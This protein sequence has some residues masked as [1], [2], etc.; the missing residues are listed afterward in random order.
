VAEPITEVVTAHVPGSGARMPQNDVERTSDLAVRAHL[1]RE[2]SRLRAL[3]RQRPDLFSPDLVAVLREIGQA[4]REAAAAS[5]S[6]LFL[7]GI[8]GPSSAEDPRTPHPGPLPG[9]PGRGGRTHSPPIPRRDARGRDPVPLA[10]EAGSNDSVPL[11]DRRDARGDSVPLADRR[12]VRGDSGSLAPV[13]RGEGGGE[14][15]APPPARDAARAVLRDTF[16]YEAFRPGQEEIIGAVLAGRDCVGVMPTGAGKSLTYQIPARVL[17]GTTLV[18]S[19]L[20][21][22]MKDQVD[23]VNE[24]GLRATFLNS[25]LSPEERRAR[26][27][28]VAA[29]AFELVYAAPEGI[30]AW[31]GQILA[32]TTLRL[33]AVDEAHCISQWGHDFRPAYRNLAGLKRRFGALPMLALTATATPEVT[34]DIIQQLA[35]QSP[36]VFRGSFFRPNLHLHGYRK[37]ETA[38]GVRKQVLRLVRSRPGQSGIIYCLS[39]RATESTAEFLR[40]HGVSALAYHAGMEP[41]ERTRV[42][43]AFR[44]DDADVVVATVAFGMGIDKSNIR[45]VIHRDMPRS[46]EGYYQEIGRAGRDGVASD[47]VLFYSWADVA[48]YDRM[49]DDLPAELA[50]RNRTQVREMFRLAESREC[51]HQQ[52]TAYLGET[53]AP[54]GSSCDVCN[55]GDLVAA[56]RPIIERRGRRGQSAASRA[57]QVDPASAPPQGGDEGLFVRLKLLRKTLADARHVPA[58][59]VFSDAT[60]LKM[61][62]RRPRSLDDLRTVPGV[63]PK[64]LAEYGAAFLHLLQA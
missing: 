32:R 44:R 43:D 50:T 16:G 54:C 27:A 10:R 23:A 45:F 34:R 57:A 40:D 51:R 2:V 55:G 8:P 3:W 59:I 12:D 1:E 48:G 28:G 25:S 13:R 11:A 53:L 36:T 20:I 29:G 6:T 5:P 62:E 19:P 14:G 17:G 47:C 15:P 41:D 61:A 52:I 42:Q 30:E 38:E 7:P 26:V 63:G 35:M 18:I 31:V 60:L 37:G 39:R 58:Y 33:I 64:K 21:A 22:L 46:V 24:V 56:A 9:G 49:F 4:L